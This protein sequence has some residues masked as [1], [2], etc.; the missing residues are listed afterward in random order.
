VKCVANIKQALQVIRD[1]LPSTRLLKATL[2]D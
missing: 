1:N 2:R